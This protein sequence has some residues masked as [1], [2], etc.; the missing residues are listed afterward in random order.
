MYQDF[1][2]KNDDYLD[3][4]KRKVAEQK[5]AS[6]EERRH[7]LA[8]ARN[9]F[10][11]TFAGIFLAGVVGWFV[12]APQYEKGSQEIPTIHRPQTAVKVKPENRGGM[13]I[14]NQD[15]DVYNLVEKK[16]VDNT[17]VENLLP[18]PEKPRLP[19]IAPEEI[20]EAEN[21]VAVDEKIPATKE[22]AAKPSVIPEKP[23]DLI[24]AKE[25][26]KEVKI[27]TK[28]EKN[29]EVT[30]SEPKSANTGNGNWQIQLLASKNK[31]AV[32]KS[33]TTLCAKYPQLKAYKHELQTSPATQG[34]TFYKLR[35]GNFA[36]EADA[37]DFCTSLKSQGLKDCIARER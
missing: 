14:P 15:K 30:V 9:N 11:G 29:K 1:F 2:N 33:W 35:A 6:M 34:G 31:E 17:V 4:F 7:E 18:E 10:L 36:S 12:L 20:A 24:V 28:P 25:P 3:E 32:E 23:Q 5:I 19:D 22:V 16:D 21:Q 8:R 37:L 27:E 13:D 26:E